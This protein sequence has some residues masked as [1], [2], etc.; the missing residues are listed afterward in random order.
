[1]ALEQR[2]C[3]PT[4]RTFSIATPAAN[5]GVAC[6][7]DNG[8]VERAS[9]GDCETPKDSVTESDARA[10][11]E[12]EEAAAAAAAAA[13]KATLAEKAAAEE[14]DS[15]SAR[16]SDAGTSSQSSSSA[17]A[18]VREVVRSVP[19]AGPFLL[20][21]KLTIPNV[22]ITF[23]VIFILNLLVNRLFPKEKNLPPF[24]SPGVPVFGALLPEP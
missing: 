15:S 2:S 21:F 16:D 4:A 18:K 12:A 10:T 11:Q 24:Y 1:M 19:Y 7:F 3:G 8:A 22:A 5:G 23:S 9:L 14:V 6:Q 17:F 20:D 13:E